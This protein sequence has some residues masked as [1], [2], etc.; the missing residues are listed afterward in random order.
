MAEEGTDRG[1]AMRTHQEE[2]MSGQGRFYSKS[3]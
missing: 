3:V 1:D 2:T